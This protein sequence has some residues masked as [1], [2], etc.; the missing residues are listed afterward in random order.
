MPLAACSSEADLLDT[1]VSQESIEQTSSDKQE[2]PDSTTQADNRPATSP[3]VTHDVTATE[4][5]SVE[6]VLGDLD[7]LDVVVNKGRA[8][9][10]DFVPEDLVKPDIPCRGA[11]LLVRRDVAEALAEMNKAADAAVGKQIQLVSGYRSYADQEKTYANY[12]RKDGVEHADTYSARAGYSEHQ[13][14]LA[15]DL[16]TVRGKIEKFGKTELGKWVAENSWRYGFIMRYTDENESETGYQS[17]PWHYRFIGKELAAEY[18]DSGATS[19]E[20]FLGAP[21]APA[22][23]EP[24]A[25]TPTTTQP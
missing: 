7:A 21:A 4:T 12:V 11:H 25:A 22:Y 1:S 9:P 2:T 20:E 8:L 24:S 6:D 14:G 18:H 16:S 10:A 17:E 15:V 23:Y 5:R 19:L 13:T 3:T